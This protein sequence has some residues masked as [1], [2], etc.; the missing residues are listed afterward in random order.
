MRGCILGTSGQRLDI[1]RSIRSRTLIALLPVCPKGERI[2][3]H[4]LLSEIFG[5]DLLI[6]L[7]VVVALMGL[8]G[9]S[10]WAIV[11]VSSHSKQDFYT[12]GSSKVAWIIVI[13][14]F[15]VFYG[16]GSLIAIYY[17]VRVRPKV[18]K[19]E[20][21][22]TD[23]RLGV[24]HGYADDSKPYCSNCGASVGTGSKY[25]SSCGVAVPT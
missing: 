2:V 7:I 11:D 6:V 5:P 22:S 23:A 21:R 15:T 3:G 8:L 9:L 14:L 1:H 19:A 20:E 10:I 16:F 17:L 25:C 12:A 18:R 13:A 4:M 24:N